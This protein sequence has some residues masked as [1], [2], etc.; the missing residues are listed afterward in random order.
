MNLGLCI[1]DADYY[2][3]A[4]QEVVQRVGGDDVHIFF[5]S[6]DMDWVR[7][8][9]LVGVGCEHTLVDF[10]NNNLGYLDLFL[11]SC[12]NHQISSN[13]SFGFWGGFLNQ[14]ENKEI[15]ELT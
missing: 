12:C 11:I 2:R 7:E 15:P 8:N 6:N 4:I 5:F 13:S 3:R 9:V 1:L 14:Y 10:N